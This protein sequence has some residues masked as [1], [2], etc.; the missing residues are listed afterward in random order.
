MS[1][2]QA[3]LLPTG[4]PRAD[5]RRHLEIA[6][7][8]AQRRA[9]PR[10]YAA[11]VAVAGIVAILLAQ[12]LMSIVLAD[13]AYRIS[14]LQRE[15]RDLGRDRNAA[16][17]RLEAL[18]STQSLLQNATALGMVPSGNPVFLDVS[19]G[20]PLGVSAPASGQQ[21]GSGGNLVG[22]AI[23]ADGTTQLDPAVI[24]AALA[25]TSGVPAVLAAADTATSGPVPGATVVAAPGAAAGPGVAA[26]PAAPATIPSPT[27]R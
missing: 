18:S 12:L 2:T 17:E 22:N 11:L 6:P 23:L 20:Q 25:G 4:S 8:R 1:A 24:A 15:Q 7:S 26:P 3:V 21:V 9:R 27:T 5:E 10:I 16:L 13:G 14:S 19:A